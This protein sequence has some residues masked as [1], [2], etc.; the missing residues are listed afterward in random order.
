VSV[1]EHLESIARRLKRRRLGLFLDYDGTLTPIVRRPEDATLAEEVRA[2]LGQLA[3]CCTVAIVS[4]RDRQDVEA[5]VQV[6]SLVYAGSHGFDIRG[7]GGIER[8][9]Q[10]ATPAL[11]DLAEAERQIR[12][13]LK[14]IHGAHVERKKFALAVHY[15]E[16]AD[17]DVKRVESAVDNVHTA[18]P[19]LRKKGG[20]RVFEL[21]PDADWDKGRAVLWLAKFLGMDDARDVLIYIGDDVTDEDAFRALR[22]HR[23]GVGIGVGV[24]ESSTDA[25]YS[26]RDCDDVQQFLRWLLA[27]L[28]DEARAP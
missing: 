26:L 22:H 6:E 5:M 21:Q 7:P 11:P 3:E 10:D 19:R 14:P 24:P 4:G 28:Q 15:R 20:K 9:H 12:Q 8:Q 1:W 23:G 13:R 27:V 16:V 17:D 25:S 2:L 18:F